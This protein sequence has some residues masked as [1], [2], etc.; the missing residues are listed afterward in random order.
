MSNEKILKMDSTIRDS[1]EFYD[2]NQELY[3]VFFNKIKYIKF[4]DNINMTDEIIFYDEN[5]KILLESSYEILGVFLP[6]TQMWKWSWSIPSFK[7]KH[8]FI[9]R[10]ILEY[11][12]NLDNIKEI[13]LR[14]DL[15]NSKIKIINDLQLD[16]HIALSSYIGKQPLIFKFYN[17]FEDNT[18]FTKMDKS[19][20]EQ[21][22]QNLESSNKINRT[23]ENLN[24]ISTKN[25]SSN[26]SSDDDMFKYVSDDDDDENYMIMYLFILDYKNIII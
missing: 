18:E 6:K 1:L 8:T 21:T 22:L 3:N 25:I 19:N 7:K 11:A 2:K 24:N 12:F 13:S 16:I 4:I 10:K 23:S 14:S 17:K 9:S 5:K 26:S 15:T 20:S